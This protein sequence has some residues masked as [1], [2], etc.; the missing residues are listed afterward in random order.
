MS[1]ARSGYDFVIV[2]GGSAG[3]LLAYRLSADPRRSVL[4]LEAGGEPRDP[5]IGIPLGLGLMH[6]HRLHDW[7]YDTEPEPGLGGRA[8][9]AMRG[10]VLG[11][12]SAINH[13]SHV[14]GNPGDYDRWA[15]QGLAGWSYADL[16]PYF[17]RYETWE[18]GADLYRGGDGPLGVTSS[19][20]NDPVADAFIAAGEALGL[21]Y[22]PDINGARQDGI[23][24]GQTT[25]RNGRRHSAAAAFL[26][27][28]RARPNLTIET[29]AFATRLNLE[30]RRVTGVEYVR[31][32]RRRTA[33]AAESVIL[34]AGVFNTPQLLMLSGIGP[35]EALL[36]HGIAPLLDRPRVGRNLQDHL[37]AM[38]A[39][40]R[41]LAGSFQTQLRADRMALNM[42]RAYFLGSGPATY[43]PGGLHGYARLG[44]DSP[45]PDIQ[46]M[47]RG[48]SSHPHL[49]FPGLVKPHPDSLGVRA[50]LLHP[51]SRGH[52]ALASA[53]PFARVRVVQNFLAEPED[54]DRLRRGVRLARALLQHAALDPYRGKELAP[55]P[56]A[57]DDAALD[58]WIARTALTAHHPCGTCAMGPE[59]E[60]VLDPELRLRGIDKLRVVDASAMPDLVSGNINAC[61]LAIADRASDLILG[62][63]PLRAAAPSRAERLETLPA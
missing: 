3:C 51:K 59:A 42:L 43:L 10:K 60:A 32:G 55:G 22:T 47:F 6:E 17:R 8:I 11:G 48:V 62:R 57:D 53:D 13:M 29:R 40:E 61:V 39:A 25:I 9:E 5:L 58:R 54:R 50:I 35:A 18:K 1:G 49:W 2:G 19:R 63:P 56:A 26:D 44:P 12:S 15:A 7:G 24:R 33:E 45:V 46:L 21:R 20:W 28:A 23:G 52:V 30:G 31:R 34:S 37:G 27:P 16:L 38:A 14:R 41:P 36:A 4:L